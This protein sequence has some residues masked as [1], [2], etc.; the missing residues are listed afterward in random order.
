MNEQS[1][2]LPRIRI[3]AN[4]GFLFTDL[5]F[6]KRIP[7]AARDGFDGVE[8]HWPFDWPVSQIAEMLREAKIPMLG[9]NTCPG[10]LSKGEFGLSALPSKIAAARHAI[11]Q[12]V[13]YGAKLEAKNLHVMAG[14]TNRDEESEQ[15]FR[16]NLRYACDT[17][18]PHDITI[19]IEPLNAI[20]HP[21]YHLVSTTHAA[22]II[23]ELDQSNLKMIFDIHH[24]RRGGEDISARF[25]ELRDLVGHIQIAGMSD[26]S[27]PGQTEQ[28]FLQSIRRISQ[29]CG[30]Q[31]V[32]AEYRPRTGSVKAGLSWLNVLKAGLASDH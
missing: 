22:E 5:P 7:A 6:L 10:A 27:E 11:R 24:V 21:D 31:W 29:Q 17:A 13:N 28:D 26:R 8:C 4:L 32:G 18:G 15:T 19:L 16:D 20:D 3:A 2:D 14:N 1:E 30:D 23:S 9:L 25:Q 12:A